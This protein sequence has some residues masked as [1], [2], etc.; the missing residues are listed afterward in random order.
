MGDQ[1]KIEREESRTRKGKGV[2][3][4]FSEWGNSCTYT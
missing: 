2:V 1:R 3:G 4:L